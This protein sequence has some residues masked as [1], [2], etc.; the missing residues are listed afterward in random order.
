[1]KNYYH[2]RFFLPTT[3]LT[4]PVYDI[5]YG[6]FHQRGNYLQCY[7]PKTLWVSFFTKESHLSSKRYLELS[8]KYPDWKHMSKAQNSADCDLNHM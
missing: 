5:I 4:I 7:V 6:A 2:R 8:M 1:M 3:R